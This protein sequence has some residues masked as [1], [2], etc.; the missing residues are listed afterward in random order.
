MRLD[1]L[2][3]DGLVPVR[4]FGDDYYRFDPEGHRLVGEDHGRAYRLGDTVEVRLA[5]ADERHRGLD[6]EIVR[7]PE[8]AGVGAGP[9]D[10]GG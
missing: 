10:R 8:P 2:H 6:L 3:V 7:R 9:R 4:T 1:E 5:G